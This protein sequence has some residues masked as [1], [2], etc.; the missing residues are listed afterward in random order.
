MKVNFAGYD[1]D[2]SNIITIGS[3]SFDIRKSEEFVNNNIISNEGELARLY[4]DILPIPQ[5]TI[6]DINK[7]NKN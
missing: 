5:R 2:I 1:Y 3:I 4:L 6:K 7:K